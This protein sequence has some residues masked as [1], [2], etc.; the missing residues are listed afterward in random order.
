MSSIR[1]K[2]R[3]ENI[4]GVSDRTART[5]LKDLSR[6]SRRAQMREI[7]AIMRAAKLDRALKQSI[8]D[9]LID[10]LADAPA[11]YLQH[12]RAGSIEIVV[13]VGAVGIWLLQNTLGETFKD[14]WKETEFH[15]AVIDW[16]KNKRAKKMANV[17]RSEAEKYDFLGGRAHASETSSEDG[18]IE[19]TLE[20]SEYL[21]IG[22]DQ[23]ITEEVVLEISERVLRRSSSEDTRGK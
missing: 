12:A 14:A 20:K 19:I 17:L 6:V 8:R 2:L 21:E 15:N 23:A 18:T 11:Y 16:V 10:E 1:I 3:L 5:L 4:Q 13:V 9:R 22:R 7:E